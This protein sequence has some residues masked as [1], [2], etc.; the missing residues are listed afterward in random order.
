MEIRSFEIR[1]TNCTWAQAASGAALAWY[2]M[3]NVQRIYAEAIAANYSAQREATH[4]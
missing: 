4:D 2:I 3:Q 1:V